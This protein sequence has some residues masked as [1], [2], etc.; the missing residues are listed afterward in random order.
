MNLSMV[1]ESASQI[2]WAIKRVMEVDVVIVD[3][4]LN[5]IT[6]TFSYPRQRIEIRK[7]S[8]VGRI[9]ENGKPLAIDDKERFQSCI[10]CKDFE[11]CEMKS[12]IGV[13]IVYEDK[14]IGAMALAISP[15][16]IKGLFGNLSHTIGFL[17]K[18]AEML[19]GKLQTESDYQ[20]LN[21]AKL[22][23]EVLIDSMNE[24]IVLVDRD[25]LITYSNTRF[26]DAFFGGKTVINLP[27]ST[28]IRHAEIDRF[29]KDK[30]SFED[31]LIYCEYKGS[32][33]F[34]GLC[35]ARTIE[36]GGEYYGAV[37]SLKSIN[38]A[39]SAVGGTIAENYRFER[40]KG[41]SG[42]CRSAINK[43]R[44]ASKNDD[45]V[46]IEGV[47]GYRKLELAQAIHE[48][49]RRGQGNFF[50]ID[51]SMD[52]DKRIEAELFGAKENVMT[53]KLRLANKGTVCICRVDLMPQY[54]QRR[55]SDY[56]V[57]RT[58]EVQ[59]RE[60]GTDTR[61]I[62]TVQGTLK[63]LMD[64]G[65]F[66]QQLYE[67]LSRQ[68]I[69]LPGI[70]DNAEDVAIYLQDALRLYAEKYGMQTPQIDPKVVETLCEYDWPGDLRQLRNVAEHLIIH[71]KNRPIGMELLEP[72]SFLRDRQKQEKSAGQLVEDQI[73]RLMA[74][75][76]TR[77]EI[78]AILQI[79]RATLFRKLKK[80]NMQ[81]EQE[82]D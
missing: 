42:R 67:Q 38:N 9:I 59:G 20:R 8:I 31:K 65:M 50:H 24:A 33:S 44:T 41:S 77:D 25:G 47:C 30:Q 62:F 28:V 19:V 29:L 10:E 15:K 13:P 70:G 39:A 7:N 72:L 79:S 46:L 43:A 52:S 81:G 60:I 26:N 57:H 69:Y 17:E 48:E 37:F 23:R 14:V 5:R 49:S 53:S 78:A 55:I 2:A 68:S 4:E 82:N 12:L 58:I 11:I 56:L 61:L 21:L 74:S 40:F 71:C 18:M 22:Q 35:S 73:L 75:G 36:I 6:D 3:N 27:V 34:D 76:K 32:S 63:P 45:P 1:T 54:L 64:C 80:I 51:C 16:F 66:D